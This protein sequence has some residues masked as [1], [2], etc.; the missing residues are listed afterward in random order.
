MAEYAGEV[1]S[2]KGE[3]ER[4]YERL[5]RDRTDFL[6]EARHNAYLTLD[7]GLFEPSNGFCYE[8]KQN[9]STIGAEVVMDAASSAVALEFPHQVHWMQ[10]DLEFPDDKRQKTTDE[11][12][13]LDRVSSRAMRLSD[14]LGLPTWVETGYQQAFIGS[15]ALLHFCQA[16][17]REEGAGEKKRKVRVKPQRLRLMPLS[18]FVIDRVDQTVRRIICKWSSEEQPSAKSAEGTAPATVETCYYTEIDYWRGTI[19]QQKAGSQEQPTVVKDGDNP[20]RWVL[21]EHSMPV[22][23]R[24]YSRAYVSLFYNLIWKLEQLARSERDII[25]EMAT[26]I[27]LVMPNSGLNYQEVAKWAGPICVEGMP[28]SIH[29]VEKPAMHYDLQGVAAAI[30]RDEGNLRQHFLTGL[31]GRQDEDAKRT[32][33]E[34][35]KIVEEMDATR[36]RLYGYHTAHVLRACGAAIIDLMGYEFKTA[37]GG[38]VDTVILTG[39]AALKK[40]QSVENL[41]SII[42]FLAQH[43]ADFVASLPVT[44]LF[45]R[46]SSGANIETDDLIGAG[47]EAKDLVQQLLLLAQTDPEGVQQA[48]MEFMQSVGMEGGPAMPQGVAAGMM[49][50]QQPAQQAA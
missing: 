4:D 10:V 27:R 37:E 33:T 42:N 1:E 39:I 7:P 19:R 22:I 23:G 36:A 49:G 11:Q 46:M 15:C 47:M 5:S 9:A 48:M 20:K 44:K 17:E 30:V 45:K 16:E 3:L 29:Y 21:I 18:Q 25:G 40:M 34:I 13:E 43:R 6:E 38:T 31:M 28:N 14:R 35:I 50:G 26:L 12:V 2:V 24:N 41:V 32:A 8:R